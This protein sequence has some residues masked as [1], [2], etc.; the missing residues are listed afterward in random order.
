MHPTLKHNTISL[1]NRAN[2]QGDGVFAVRVGNHLRV[3]RL[4]WLMDGSLRIMSDNPAYET[5][6]IAAAELAELSEQF[7]IIG[8]C[9]MAISPIL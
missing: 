3:K 9:R 6:E 1:I 7:A 4:Q 5:E 8:E 2:T